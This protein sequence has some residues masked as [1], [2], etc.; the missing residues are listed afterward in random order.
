M[1][2]KL[3]INGAH[4]NESNEMNIGKLIQFFW[5]MLSATWLQLTWI[6]QSMCF[7]CILYVYFI[8]WNSL[9]CEQCKRLKKPYPYMRDLAQFWKKPIHILELPPLS[10]MRKQS[11]LHS[12]DIKGKIWFNVH[13]NLVR[14][15]M[16]T[17]WPDQTYCCMHRHIML[18]KH[19]KQCALNVV[20][21]RLFRNQSHP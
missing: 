3:E 4:A 12:R 14:K 20:S 11:Y 5:T 8:Q 10:Q 7:E 17:W 15:K 19:L 1:K 21:F 2:R 16:S 13:F 9:T 6:V 18:C